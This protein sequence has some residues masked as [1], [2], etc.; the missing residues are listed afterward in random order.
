MVTMYIIKDLVVWEK[1]FKVAVTNN[2]EG[3]GMEQIIV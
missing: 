1:N 2:L 3:P